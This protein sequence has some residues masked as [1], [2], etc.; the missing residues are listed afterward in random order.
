MTFLDTREI[1]KSINDSVYS[2][3]E[4]KIHE[5]KLNKFYD[6][7]KSE[8]RGQN[9]TRFIFAGLHNNV[10]NIKSV[11]DVDECWVE[12]GQKVTMN[13][14]T[15]LIPSIRKEISP[16]CFVKMDIDTGTGLFYCN[17]C[18][19]VVP[20]D[21]IIPSRIVVTYNPELTEDPTEQIFYVNRKHRSKVIQMNYT[22]NPFFP[23]VLRE[24][25]ESDREKKTTEHFRH[26]WL[27]ECLSSI[28]GAVFEE[29]MAK[30]T[31]EER[32]TDVPYDPRYPVLTFWDLG[33]SDQTC[34][35]FIQIV[36]FQYRVIDYYENFGYK[37]PHYIKHIQSQEYVYGGHYL[38]HDAD[39]EQLGQEATVLEQARAA[40]G[41]V[42]LVPRVKFKAHALSQASLALALS[43]FDK[44]R[45]A[46]GVTHLR[47]Y[48]YA[49]SDDGEKRSKEP[50]HNIHS[51]GSDAYQTFGT[52]LAE[53]LVST[54]GSIPQVSGYPRQ[55]EM[56]DRRRPRLG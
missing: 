14:W 2:L 12:E 26:I 32:I 13:S 16:C 5:L 23:N 27:G 45:T 40:L 24:E 28:P 55:N 41:N 6:V 29:E 33:H 35:W 44:E 52:A 47:K 17:K 49:V 50:E 10:D 18:N 51:H 30:I 43:W 46:D 36:G 37:M 48:A 7:L 34:I 54:A 22:D 53:G 21:K 11:E 9:G 3:L 42:I 25:M 31:A 8:I 4:K 20:P 19:K 38:P 39:H 56:A 15:K 1:Q